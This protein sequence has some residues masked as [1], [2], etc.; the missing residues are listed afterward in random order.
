[1]TGAP[2]ERIREIAS[3]D[4]FLC[5]Q[6]RVQAALHAV[7]V[8]GDL[9]KAYS[10]LS[11]FEIP[12]VKAFAKFDRSCLVE[13]SAKADKFQLPYVVR[14]LKCFPLPDGVDFQELS[15]EFVKII[16]RVQ[17]CPHI[18]APL[19]DEEEKNANRGVLRRSRSF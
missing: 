15:K 8:A 6:E 5:D 18:I 19:Q 2:F 10:V 1:M 7:I 11:L 16:P 14:L 9:K 17:K 4:K 12:T 13:G 3:K